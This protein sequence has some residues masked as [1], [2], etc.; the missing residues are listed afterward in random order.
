MHRIKEHVKQWDAGEK[1][2]QEVK[3]HKSK[4]SVMSDVDCEAV[5][6]DGCVEEF[7]R[8]C[9]GWKESKGR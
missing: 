7:G 3:S 4:T 5:G 9:S 2:P 6:G 8:V 1:E